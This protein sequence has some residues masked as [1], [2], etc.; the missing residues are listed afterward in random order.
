VNDLPFGDGA[1]FDD[2]DRGLIGSL[3]PCVVKDATG[4]VVW[5]NDVFVFLDGECPDTA[6]PS[7][8]RQ[9]QLCARQGLYEVADGIYQVRGLDLSN[10]TLVE[11]DAGVVVI[12]PLISTEVA[13]AA[14]GLYR[15]HR[16]D[17]PVT[18]VIYT[19]SHGDHF[20]GVRGVVTGDVPILAPAG[21]LEHAVEENVYAGGAMNRRAVYMYGAELDKS[22]EG[23]IG[24]GLG[25]TT[26]TGTVSLIPPTVDI[27]RTGQQET[28]DGVL[29]EFQLTP[30]PRR[31]RR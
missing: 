11:G 23:H 24:A 2:A 19:H 6:N 15:E 12:D 30:G 1:D 22:P 5:D 29:I 14:L 27:T 17:R 3:T 8:W 9:S 18:G 31:P 16:G 13:A 21:F 10:M 26:S 4:R 7:L 25:M 28:V 20:G